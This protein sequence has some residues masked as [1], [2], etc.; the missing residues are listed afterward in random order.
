[1]MHGFDELEIGADVVV[2]KASGMSPPK[3]SVKALLQ[4]HQLAAREGIKHWK[5]DFSAELF[6]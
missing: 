2:R 3:E 4:R 6:Q 1:M 5:T